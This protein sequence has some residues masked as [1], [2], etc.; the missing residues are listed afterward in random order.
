MES[1][2]KLSIDFVV[3]LSGST[4]IATL[5]LFQNSPAVIIGAMIIAPLMRPL[6]G[7]S[8]ATLTG[9]T[10]LL[11]RAGLTLVAGTAV[12]A[13]IA[14]VM[15]LCVRSLE[16]SPEIL[17]RTHPTLLDLGVALFAGAVGAYCQ[18]NEKLADTLAGV[19]ISVALVPPL[20][21]VGIGLAFNATA[22]WSGAALL[23]ATNLIGITVAGAIAFLVM[24]YTPPRLARRGLAISAVVTVLLIVPLA[25]SMRELVLE[26]Q[27]SSS[28]R[29]IL[30]EKTFTFKGVQLHN[31]EVKRFRT[32]M[33]VV[34]TVLG[35]GRPI[36]A[37]QVKLV[38]DFLAKEIGT[39]VEFSLRIIPSVELT[40]VEVGSEAEPNTNQ[41]P[42]EGAAM[43]VP[44][45]S[46]STQH[47]QP[48]VKRSGEDAAPAPEKDP[49]QSAPQL[50]PPGLK[51]EDKIEG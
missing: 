26:N 12:G 18:A 31:L 24:G 43:P 28:V 50:E 2:S 35:A 13:T 48:S 33:K 45:Q 46:Q 23:Y 47:E 32:P 38:Q 20:S 36:T 6:L 4:I 34:A 7:L 40:A 11:L 30:K 51:P 42:V 21:V 8:L 15:S 14:T 16:L 10:R 37:H 49:V 27:I 17:G 22:V 41:A 9:D 39:P 29:Q 25:L 1:I 5:G 3:L 44:V 19:A